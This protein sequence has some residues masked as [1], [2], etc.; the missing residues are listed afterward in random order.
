MHKLV[1]IECGSNR[2]EMSGKSLLTDLS[3]SELCELK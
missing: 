2:F 3:K 1:R